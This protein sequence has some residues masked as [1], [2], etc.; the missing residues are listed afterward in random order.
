LDGKLSGFIC[1]FGSCTR[2]LRHLHL[3]GV[4]TIGGEL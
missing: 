3:A 4:D 1:A 2:W